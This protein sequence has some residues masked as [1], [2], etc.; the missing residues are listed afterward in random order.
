MSTICSIIPMFTMQMRAQKSRLEK[1]IASFG[2]LVWDDF[3]RPSNFWGQL[4]VDSVY[5]TLGK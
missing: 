4:L 1:F 2:S 5:R 3:F